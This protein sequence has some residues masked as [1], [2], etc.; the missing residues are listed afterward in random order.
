MNKVDLEKASII[1]SYLSENVDNLHVT[2]LL[3]LFYYID[4]VSYNMR[5]ASVTGD[6]YY[7]LPYGPVPSLIK[8]EIDN[9]SE[10]LMGK[11]VKSQFSNYLKL[12]KDSDKN[13]KI[14]KSKSGDYNIRKLSNF[15][16]NLLKEVSK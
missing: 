7:K 16:I 5:G 6:T 10:E 1:A 3:K 9:L 13:G 14:V 8:N 15:E 11:K 12:E 4:F 2:K